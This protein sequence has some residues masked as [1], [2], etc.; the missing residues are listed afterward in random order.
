[1][2]DQIAVDQAL[3]DEEE[4]PHKTVINFAATTIRTILK[5]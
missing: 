2:P 3:D 1:M 4:L 5:V